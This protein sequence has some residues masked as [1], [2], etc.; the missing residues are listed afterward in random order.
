M[1]II[2]SQANNPKQVADQIDALIDEHTLEEAPELTDLAAHP[3]A[4]SV[5]VD[6]QFAGGIAFRQQYDTL[7]VGGLAVASK[8][9]GMR[10]GAQLITEMEELAK[11][12]SVHTVSLSTLS[13]Q[14]LGFYQSLGYSVCGQLEDYPRRGVTKY[15]LYKR[16]S[17]Y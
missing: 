4:I 13:Y 7:H 15:H 3:Y 17:G 1:N 6:G 9:R 8:Y 2:Y 11:E 5:L 10:I 12:L 14:A 16:L